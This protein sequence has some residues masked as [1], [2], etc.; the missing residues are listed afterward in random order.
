M[1]PAVHEFLLRLKALF[2]KRRM[3]REMADE[4]AF[5]QAMLREKL[6]RQGIAPTEIDTLA[7]RRFGRTAKWHE[8]LR[9]L[10]QFRRLENFMRD[11][12]FSA[13]VLRKSPGF[14]IVAILTLALGVGANTTVFSV[15]NGLLLRPLPVPASNQLVLFGE[16]D[17]GF[18]GTNYSLSEPLFRG[19][20][21]RRG[22]SSEVF[23]F[24]LHILQV[25]G[26]NGNENVQGDIV[27]GDFFS[28][29][30]T[31]PLMGRTL[32]PADD[33]RGG[34]PAG[35]G[36]VISESFWER[37]FNRTPAVIGQKLQINNRLVTVVGVMPK[38]FIGA[39][40][41]ERPEL[42]VPLAAEPILE[43]TRSMVSAGHHA[44]WLTVMA[45]MN[46][47]TTLEQVHADVAAASSAVLHAM[48]PDAHWVADR[49]NRHFLFTA[50]SGST[51]FTYI[52]QFFT[53]PLM[54]VFAMCGGVLLLACLNLA[55]LLMARGMARQKELAT[56]M[57]MGATRRRL[58]QQLMVESLLVAL[59]GTTAGLAIAPLVSQSLAAVL[60]GGGASQTIHIDTSLDLRVFAFAALAAI[61]AALLIGLLPA[62]RATSKNLNEQ[63]KHG[64]HTTLAYERQALFP[65]LI[66]GMEVALAL[67]LI[68]GAGLLATSLVRLYRS[69]TGF[70]PRGLENIAFSMDQ[71]PLKGDAL[72]DF[73]RQVGEGLSHQPGVKNVSFA[74]LVPFSHF[75]WDGRLTGPTG[76]IENTHQNTVAPEYFR[77]MRIPLREGR[78][79]SWNDTSTTTP[80]VILNLTAAKALV[81]DRDPLGQFIVDTNEK[82]TRYEVVGLVGDAKYDNLR[83]PAPPTAYFPLPQDSWEQS[84]SVYAVVR[85]DAPAAP[86]IGAAHTLAARMVPGI[87][88]PTIE[89]A[90]DLVR[91]AMSAERMMALLS[92][93]FALCALVVTAIGLYGTLAYA[94]ARRTSE[95]GIRM[96]L[97]A[98]RTQVA[99]LVFFQN[100]AVAVSGTGAGIVAALL[101]SRAL[102]S[103]LFGTS[104]R[105]PWVFA[106]SV[107]A[108]A[109]IASAA[110]LLPAIRAA[111]I[112]PMDA[113]RCE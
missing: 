36:V 46:P 7:Q 53:K 103:F 30:R 62:V 47:G 15:I 37:W 90:S 107:L 19:L 25:K 18:P 112:Q 77:T 91:D 76:K 35:F 57:A 86:L 105:D 95:I 89:S 72:V 63:M 1:S 79:F 28:A 39:N 49:E 75:I 78:E 32:T 87:P 22:L 13:R 99:R 20:E 43:G 67:M 42:F 5:H 106:V 38:R 52:R 14:T 97:G 110:S 17:S 68:V 59:A 26:S 94:T 61:V 81:P 29:L 83:E 23:A 96:A 108:L 70:D 104:A 2:S 93:F 21:K 9:E 109:L 11:I 54:A 64:Q 56:R 33:V 45:R 41:L 84:R 85:T 100:A 111:T 74:R 51:G 80:K 55:S 27:S 31:P 44:W 48:I 113:I 58:I 10:W 98:R 102:A 4:L 69:G 50:E 88:M 40:P 71:Q 16:T 8:R 73:Y 24:N 82:K 34:N 12:T 3:D 101:S 92:V 60:L 66:M 6:L 65:R